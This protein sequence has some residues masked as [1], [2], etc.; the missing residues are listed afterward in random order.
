MS[1][2]DEPQIGKFFGTLGVIVGLCYGASLVDGE[3]NIPVILGGALVGG[4]LGYII[5]HILFRVAMVFLFLAFI[6]VRTAFFEAVAEQ[7]GAIEI[8]PPAY[9]EEVRQCAP[10]AKTSYGRELNAST[11]AHKYSQENI[12]NVGISIYPGA[13]LATNGFSSANMLGDVIISA[14]KGKNVEAECFVNNTFFDTSGTA[15]SFKINGLSIKIDGDDT[16][17][18]DEVWHDKRILRAAVAE[19]KT[20]KLLQASVE[21]L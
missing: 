11:S 12:G 17:N 14:L 8:I 6:F 5:E 7:F 2:Q 20:V 1:N 21:Q 4:T 19:A 18:M 10:L 3:P 9:A 15:L 16:F 13:D